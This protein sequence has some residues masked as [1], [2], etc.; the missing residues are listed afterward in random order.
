M[1][2]MTAGGRPM[3]GGMMGIDATGD[4]ERHTYARA[5]SEFTVCEL[6]PEL[7]YRPAWLASVGSF[8]AAAAM[9]S[10]F[11]SH[12]MY[13]VLFGIS[14]PRHMSSILSSPMR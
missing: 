13:H 7:A 11:P 14:L 9:N 3:V 2:R 5:L 4:G 12:G 6:A 1:T 8:A 10:T